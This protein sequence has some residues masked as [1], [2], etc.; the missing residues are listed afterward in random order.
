MT[1]LQQSLIKKQAENFGYKY[2]G[3]QQFAIG[4]Q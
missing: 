2:S 3:L 1:K 4:W